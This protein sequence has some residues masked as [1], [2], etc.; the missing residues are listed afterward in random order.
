MMLFQNLDDTNPNQNHVALPFTVKVGVVPDD[1]GVTILSI[2][3]N[4][5]TNTFRVNLPVTTPANRLL[6]FPLP[7]TAFPTVGQWYTF[8]LTVVDDDPN[9]NPT[10]TRSVTFLR[11]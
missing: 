4:D 10:T 7:P 3:L 11:V 1:W 8:T 9:N 2:T 5:S 6:T